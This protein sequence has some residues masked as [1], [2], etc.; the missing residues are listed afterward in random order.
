MEELEIHKQIDTLLGQAMHLLNNKKDFL[1][2]TIALHTIESVDADNPVVLYNLAIAYIHLQDYAKAIDY[3]NRCMK[4]PMTFIDISQV[5]KLFIFV[6]L[7][8][9]Q[10]SEA[11]DILSKYDD[12]DEVL[13]QMRAFALEKTGDYRQALQLYEHILGKNPEN[14]NASNAIAY[15]LAM[16]PD[17]DL[18]RALNLAKKAVS[19]DP[20]NAA[21]NDTLGYVYLKKKQ[22]DMAKKFLKK[23]LSLK[24]DDSEI[25]KHINALLHIP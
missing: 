5:R 24:P 2:A 25:R 16:L 1:Q 7:R 15:I 8:M 3:L 9:G 21:Y 17:G 22:Y 6:L 19:Y 11:L 12:S 14:I 20:Q 4:L 18:N 13:I 10:Y 23:A